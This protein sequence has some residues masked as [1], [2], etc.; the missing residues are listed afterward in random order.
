MPSKLPTSTR[1]GIPS[2]T[3]SAS[4]NS[5]P[6][7]SGIE[8]RNNVNQE[9][10]PVSSMAKSTLSSDDHS[11]GSTTERLRPS[12]T[13][14]SS[15]PSSRLHSTSAG[16]LRSDD[17]SSVGS[18]PRYTSEPKL[19]ATARRPNT[20]SNASVRASQPQPA[21]TVARTT[22]NHL[23]SRSLNA[24][25]TSKLTE[26]RSL[27]SSGP[28]SIFGQKKS[29]ETS[30]PSQHHHSSFS[31]AKKSSPT[32]LASPAKK[33]SPQKPPPVDPAVIMQKLAHRATDAM[34]NKFVNYQAQA[35]EFF[36]TDLE[37][38]EDLDIAIEESKWL[39]PNVTMQTF[40]RAQ[41]IQSR[42]EV[43]SDKIVKLHDGG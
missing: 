23:T 42:L 31:P 37:A 12:S 8:N 38:D 9:F 17:S 15:R 3:Q 1:T 24:P 21:P 13:A 16:R 22:S 19:N 35:A 28:R 20:A 11:V 43:Q 18:G 2:R 36:R 30:A 29:T 14:S 7:S 4:S 6:K 25:A 5:L 33:L 41:K 34:D 40:L 32:K 27:P 39:T 10:K 26:T